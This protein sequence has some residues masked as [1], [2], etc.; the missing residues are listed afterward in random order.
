HGPT[1]DAEARRDVRGDDRLAHRADTGLGDH[2]HGRAYRVDPHVP[3]ERIGRERDPREHAERDRRA[4]QTDEV[5]QDADRHHEEE[6]SD[7][8]DTENDTDEPGGYS[9]PGAEVDH[10]GGERHAID[11]GADGL[12]EIDPPQY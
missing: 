7:R 4:A 8:G 5:A 10:G 3:G 2:E 11:R 12:G 9:D 1:A 6:R